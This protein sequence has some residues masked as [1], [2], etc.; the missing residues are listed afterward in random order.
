[1]DAEH[2]HTVLGLNGKRVVAIAA[3]SFHTVVLTD[4]GEVWTWGL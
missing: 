4:N 1:V 3:G 2:P